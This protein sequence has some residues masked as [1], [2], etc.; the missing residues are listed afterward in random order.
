MRITSK[1]S[2]APRLNSRNGQVMIKPTIG[3]LA[4]SVRDC[5][6][7]MEALTAPEVWHKDLL[8]CPAP[9]W[10]TAVSLR[11]PD[12]GRPLRVGMMVTDDWFE[13]CSAAQRAVKIAGKAL[14]S[15]GIEV[16]PYKSK[17]SS[18]DMMRIYLALMAADGNWYFHMKALE[19]EDLYESYKRT[20]SYTDL[21]VILREPMAAAFKFF[22]EHRKAHALMSMKSGGFNVR[23]YWEYIADW[24]EYCN[25]TI[26]EVTD[27]GLDGI[28]MPT[29][30]LVAT[31][32][33]MASDLIFQ[34][35]YTFLANILHWPA[36][37]VPVTLVAEEEA[38]YNLLD[39]PGNQKDSIAALAKVAMQG[40]KGLPVGVQVMTPMWKDETCTYLMSVI[41]SEVNFCTVCPSLQSQIH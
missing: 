21:P 10:N 31:P 8:L 6:S 19:D 37:T 29:T 38:D 40:S 14:Q 28:I 18:W 33:G 15:R 20:R 1:G 7:M 39:I 4:R 12:L 27:L 23:E 11:G 22:G 25:D 2:V 36:G 24:Q 9:S 3:P 35:S 16:V 13:A 34:L 26:Q 17:R 30:G 32:H 41:E 5:I